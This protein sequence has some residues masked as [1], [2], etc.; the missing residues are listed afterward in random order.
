M[1]DAMENHEQKQPDFTAR[2][3]PYGGFGYREY[4]TWDDSYRWELYDGIPYMMAGASEWHQRLVVE[5]SAQLRDFLRGKPCRVYVA[6]FDVRLFYKEDE[7]DKIVVQPDILVVCDAAKLSDG[8]ACKGAPD[9]IIEI[10]SDSSEAHD[11]ITK[12][13][14][15]EKAGVGEYWIVAEDTVYKYVLNEGKYTETTFDF[16]KHPKVPVELLQGCVIDF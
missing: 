1:A 11:S 2:K 9:F 5:F 14:L 8:K 12:R 16:T 10:M 6:P 4:L 3:M 7:S 13:K 15:Y